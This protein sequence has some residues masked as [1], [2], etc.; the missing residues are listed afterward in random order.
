M[1]KFKEL[2]KKFVFYIAIYSELVLWSILL[3]FIF[4]MMIGNSK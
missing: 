4:I 1:S 2:Y 3:G